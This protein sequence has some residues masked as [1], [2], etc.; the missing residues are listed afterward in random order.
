MKS[1]HEYLLDLCFE[2]VTRLDVFPFKEESTRKIPETAMIRELSWGRFT[3]TFALLCLVLVPG[4]CAVQQPQT[5]PQPTIA[6]NLNQLEQ[7]KSAEYK[8]YMNAITFEDKEQKVGDYYYSKAGEVHQ[9]IDKME[10]GQTVSGDEVNHALNDN[11]AK[12]YYKL[13]PHAAQF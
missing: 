7:L 13:P 3:A 4:G 5:E 2:R 10:S 8:D 1:H 11:D 12:Y 6:A 9:V